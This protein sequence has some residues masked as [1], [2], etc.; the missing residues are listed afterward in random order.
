MLM[1]VDK[2]KKSFWTAVTDTTSRA[3]CSVPIWY[4]HCANNDC[5]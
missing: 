3:R 1:D 2:K 4:N 5:M